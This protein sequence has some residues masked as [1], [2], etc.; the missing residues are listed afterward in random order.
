[1]KDALSPAKRPVGS[2]LSGFARAALW[3][4]A[5][6]LLLIPLQLAVFVASPPPDTAEGFLL[7]FQDS[8]LLGLMSLDLLY[9]LNNVILV[10]LYLFL[11]FRLYSEAPALGSGALALGLVGVACYFPSNPAFE[12]LTLSE[13]YAAA[14]AELRGR[15]L[16]AAE[17][18]LAGYTGTAFV[19]YYVLSAAAL[20]L[21]SWAILRGSRVPKRVG[22]WG[23]AAGILMLVPS[24]AGPVGMMFSLASLPPWIVFLLL[25]MGDCRRLLACPPRAEMTS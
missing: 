6:M 2:P 4:S 3:L 18:L 1:M 17:A 22:G 19:V 13:A 23:L 14:P 11:F 10:F 7:L 9:L 25:L 20:I 21:F 16:A 5:L 12:M 24:S 8:W 15:L